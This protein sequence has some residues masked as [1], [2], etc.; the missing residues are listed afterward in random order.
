MLK[1]HKADALADKLEK[2]VE[3]VFEWVPEIEAY[4]TT[5]FV[6]RPL[7]KRAAKMLRKTAMLETERDLL[8]KASDEWQAMFRQQTKYGEELE[9][10]RD[11]A[12]LVIDAAYE[13]LEL[14]GEDGHYVGKA[15]RIL[16]AAIKART[17]A[18]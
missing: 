8:I 10:E 18:A 3:A 6:T 4:R 16:T 15:K 7:S 12:K 14:S 17:P 5:G 11:A 13:A 2:D 9:A 1:K